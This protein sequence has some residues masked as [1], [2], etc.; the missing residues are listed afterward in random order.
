MTYKTARELYKDG[1]LPCPECDGV[2]EI[3]DEG[4]SC[5]KCEF[6][7]RIEWIDPPILEPIQ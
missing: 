6:T 5:S 3:S 4:C 1:E 7:G 2:L